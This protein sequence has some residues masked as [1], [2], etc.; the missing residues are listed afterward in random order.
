[1]TFIGIQRDLRYFIGVIS[2]SS[3]S[4]IGIPSNESGK[5]QSDEQQPYQSNIAIIS[6]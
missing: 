6:K 4:R 3:Q 2:V 5:I 1:M